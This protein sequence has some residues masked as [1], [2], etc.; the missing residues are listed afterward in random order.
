MNIYAFAEIPDKRSEEMREALLCATLA[1]NCYQASLGW[2]ASR[3]AQFS[4]SGLPYFDM[5]DSF[6]IVDGILVKGEAI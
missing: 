2:M 3:Q 5:R 6:S 1:Y 4:L